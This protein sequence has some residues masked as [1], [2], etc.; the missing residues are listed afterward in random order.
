MCL[1]A[2]QKLK[3]VEGFATMFLNY[4]LLAQRWIPYAKI[5]SQRAW[6]ACSWW[7]ER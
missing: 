3:D 7:P 4:D 1:L 5:P 2:L 6:R